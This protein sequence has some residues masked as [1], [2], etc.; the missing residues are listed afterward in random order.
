MSTGVDPLTTLEADIVT[1]HEIGHNFGSHHDKESCFNVNGGK[2][3][4]YDTSVSGE[5]DNNKV[6]SSC[7]REQI[8]GVLESKR[9]VCFTN[10]DNNPCGNSIVEEKHGEKCDQGIITNDKCCNDCELTFGS[11]CSDYNSLCCKNCHIATN[12]TVCIE[13]STIECKGEI[14]C[15]GISKDCPTEAPKLDEEECIIKSS[16][17][18]CK[19]GKCISYCSPETTNGSCACVGDDACKVCCNQSNICKPFVYENG[20]VNETNGIPCN[21]HQGEGLCTTG[22]CQLIR[23]DVKKEFPALSDISLHQAILLM[24]NNIVLTILIFSLVLWIPASCIVNYVDK[25]EDEILSIKREISR[26]SNNKVN[27]ALGEFKNVV[28]RQHLGT[29]I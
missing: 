28:S 13:S 20:F 24:E 8:G 25:E 18:K 7:S 6:F 2:Y 29:S 10:K 16:R 17:G 23:K 19:N 1:A 3:I 15:D 27:K 21:V 11:S 26:E 14:R 9:K 12:E 22:K 4:M 5:H